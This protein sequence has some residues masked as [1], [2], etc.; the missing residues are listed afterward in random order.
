MAIE[1]KAFKGQGTLSVVLQITGLLSFIS[2]ALLS[3]IYTVD[4]RYSSKDGGA[5]M[6]S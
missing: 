2:I 3:A 5:K 1:Q 4:Q 6:F